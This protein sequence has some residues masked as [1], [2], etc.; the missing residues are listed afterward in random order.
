MMEGFV[1]VM[2]MKT[3]YQIWKV[4]TACFPDDWL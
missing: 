1:V 2:E 3:T 4:E